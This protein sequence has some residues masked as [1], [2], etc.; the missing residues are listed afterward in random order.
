MPYPIVGLHH[1]TAIASNLRKR[2]SRWVRM[3]PFIVIR[4]CPTPS[5]AKKSNLRVSMFALSFFKRGR[6]PRR[7]NEHHFCWS[8]S[9]CS[10]GYGW[11]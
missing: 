9:R 2:S 8:G 6:R 1:V 11:P 10:R 5:H 4:A 3:W 7:R